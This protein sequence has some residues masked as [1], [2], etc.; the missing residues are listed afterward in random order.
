MEENKLT[1]AER[2]TAYHTIMQH[3]PLQRLASEAGEINQSDGLG[4]VQQTIEYLVGKEIVTPEQANAIDPEEISGLF[5]SEAGAHLLAAEEVW[6]E[7][8]FSYALPAAMA[9]QDL[10]FLNHSRN[11]SLNWQSLQDET[12]LIQGVVDCLFRLNGKLILLDYKT[13]RVMEHRGG[14]A[15]LVDQYRFQLDLYAKALE[16]ILGEL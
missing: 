8:P 3:L 2:G 10:D 14:I 9:Y 7:M 16:D 12:V 1:P 15:A 5:R 13:D 6:R 11:E 4:V